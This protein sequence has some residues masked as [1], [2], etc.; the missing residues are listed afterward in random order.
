MIKVKN[1]FD[2]VESDDGQR[3]W[4]E[5]CGL[6][7]DLRE[8]CAVDHVLCHLGPPPQLAEWFEDHPDDY[9]Q[10]RAIYHEALTKSRF[11]PLLQQLA[12]A[13]GR[14]NFTFV[15][16]GNDPCRNAGVALHEFISELQAYCPPE[17]T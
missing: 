1:L 11:L 2:R 15:H 8:W 6:T 17:T 5:P 13:A 7:S 16:L 10:F 9:E 3:L 14:E 12:C 4:I